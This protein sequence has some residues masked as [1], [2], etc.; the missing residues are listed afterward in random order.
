M[1]DS[2]TKINSKNNDTYKRPKNIEDHIDKLIELPIDSIALYDS[3]TKGNSITTPSEVILYFLRHCDTES[4]IFKDLFH[5]L[6]SRIENTLKNNKVPDS[7]PR[8]EY[9]RNEIMGR[10][11]ELIVDDPKYKLDMFETRF[12]KALSALTIDILRAVKPNEL[13]TTDLELNKVSEDIFNDNSILDDN[14]FRSHLYLTI[15]ELPEKQKD[16][17]GLILKGVP[18]VTISKIVNC[19]ERTVRNRRDRGYDT[20][21]QQL[22]ISMEDIK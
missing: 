18:I 8:A 13:R 7:I 22:G 15:N 9:I 2:L 10:I 3:L 11:I 6:L 20:L 19:N 12:N 21:K 4:K 14:N 16:V 17:I 5:L 1:A